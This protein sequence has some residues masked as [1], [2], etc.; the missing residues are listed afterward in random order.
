MRK[1]TPSV[2]SVS[3]EALNNKAVIIE[4]K[5]LILWSYETKRNKLIIAEEAM[6]LLSKIGNSKLKDLDLISELVNLHNEY[7]F[8]LVQLKNTTQK[9]IDLALDFLIFLSESKK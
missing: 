9:S 6:M 7:R 3:D 2:S 1:P 4:K 5:D 8:P